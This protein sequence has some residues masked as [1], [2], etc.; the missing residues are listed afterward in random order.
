VLAL[1]AGG[2]LFVA[3]RPHPFDYGV[4]SGHIVQLHN[5]VEGDRCNQR[6]TLDYD[7]AL[8]AAGDLRGALSDTDDYFAKCG[9]WYRLR[10]VTYSAHEHLGQHAAAVAEATRL[11]AHDPEDHDYPWWRA[12]AYEEM[13]RLDE[14]IADYRRTLALSPAIDRIPFNLSSVLERKGQFC[15][16]REPI[17]KFVEYHPEFADQ[18]NV[19]D[20]LDRLRIL[21]RCR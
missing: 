6:A 10:W 19:K 8:V 18:A 12:M 20:R 15:E 16:A 5:R 2:I 21:G 14:A 4:E 9:D 13:G 1:I 7:E 17:L 11:I 3:T